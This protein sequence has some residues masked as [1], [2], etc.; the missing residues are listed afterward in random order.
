MRAVWACC[1]C[2]AS[3]PASAGNWK[4]L[5]RVDLM[6]GQYFFE[7]SAGSLSG[8]G[9]ADLQLTRSIS[10]ETG[11]FFTGR[12]VYTGFKQVNELAGGGTLF[13][14]SIDNSLGAKLIRR[15]EGGYS[16]KPR[17]GVRSQ[18]FR[19]TRDE[20]WG[21]GLY[22]FTRYEGGVVWERKTRLGLSIPWTYQFSYDLY[23]TRYT[24][25]KTLS[26]QFGS[27]LAAPDP[28]SRVLDA[29]THQLGYRSE[30]DFPGFAT[31]QLVYSLSLVSFL[32]QKV[33]SAQGQYLN[34]QRSDAAQTLSLGLSKRFLDL[35]A[36]GRVRPVAGAGLTFS[37]QI[38][39][40]N[41]FDTDPSRLKFVRGYYN[42]WEVRGGPNI[43]A[44]FLKTMIHAR[45]GY[46]YAAR[47]YS[48][49]L[50]QLADGSYT[51]DKLT[52]SSQS[53]FIEA[54]YPFWRGLELKARGTWSSTSSNTKFEQ[55][56][57]YN[58]YDYNYFTGI[59]WKF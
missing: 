38:S 57:K 49:R 52:Q 42:Y 20:V 23:Y 25:F 2:L 50:A 36:L 15:Y 22:D 45:V 6:L 16:L 27:E 47:F 58:Y 37:N 33:V 32:D 4:L 19:E 39:N 26:S 51:N 31:G 18:L 5:G 7:N 43:G 41:H 14:Q 54:G 59:E 46:E 10:P 30:F 29:I 9:D 11:F 13:Q 21:K 17:V 44:T 55:T 12:S 35:E 3:M 56:Y 24:R 1:L 40:Q 53:V 34:A 48:G 8:F 28:G